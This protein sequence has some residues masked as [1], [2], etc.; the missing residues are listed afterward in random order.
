MRR[1]YYLFLVIALCCHGI[2]AEEVSVE[3]VDEFLALAERAASGDFGFDITLKNDLDFNGTNFTG[4]LGYRF[5]GNCTP[6][7]GIFEGNGHSLRGIHSLSNSENASL[8]CGI[9]DA[10]IKN[11]IIDKTCTWNGLLYAGSLAV[12]AKG[13][14][15]IENVINNANAY[16]G[17][18][19]SGFIGFSGATSLPDGTDVSTIADDIHVSFVKC[20]NNGIITARAVNYTFA[21]GFIG[22]INQVNNTS[23][24]IRN[25]TNY[26]NIFVSTSKTQTSYPFSFSCGG[27]G[28]IGVIVSD[29]HVLLAVNNCVN[30]GNIS[31]YGEKQSEIANGG[32]IGVIARCNDVS[33]TA[34]NCINFG[35]GNAV[36]MTVYSSG[37]MGMVTM[38]TNSSLSVTNLTNQGHFNS[39]AQYAFFGC[40]IGFIGYVLLSTISVSDSVNYGVFNSTGTTSVS[41]GVVGG[42]LENNHLDLNNCM[43]HGAIISSAY[44]GFLGGIVGSTSNTYTVIDIIINNCMN[45]GD[46]LCFS[47]TSFF[48]S[49]GILS[50][51]LGPAVVHMNNCSNAGDIVQSSNQNGSYG[52]GGLIGWL[53]GAEK[54]FINCENTGDVINYNGSAC[55]LFCVNSA[56]YNTTIVKNCVNK[57]SVSGVSATGISDFVSEANNVVSLGKVNGTNITYLLWDP[58]NNSNISRNTSYGIVEACEMCNDSYTTLHRHQQDGKFYYFLTND[59]GKQVRAD[60]ILNNEA[61]SKGYKKYWSYNLEQNEYLKVNVIDDEGKEKGEAVRYGDKMG[62]MKIM[63]CLKGDNPCFV[64]DRQ[65]NETYDSNHII[66]RDHELKIQERLVIVEIEFQPTESSEMNE[67]ELKEIISKTCGIDENSFIIKIEKNDKG[68]IEKVILIVRDDETADT[69]VKKVNEIAEEDPE[70]CSEGVLCRAKEAHVKGRPLI[71]E[72]GHQN[73]FSLF[74]IAISLILSVQA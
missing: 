17:I 50:S 63:K 12:E 58:T 70:K 39:T 66:K 38:I 33:V 36:S 64:I 68:Q 40:A 22:T 8:F 74:I 19:S 43:N 67:S 25:C 1:L 44:S 5:D 46:I 73:T 18:V 16:G 34:E 35:S 15:T 28:F 20:K 59:E 41:G 10:T 55:G 61:E 72:E 47:S 13:N 3:T 7:S 37:L 26:G 32:I 27:G 71:P 57:G 54:T 51:V 48:A 42:V 9:R 49:G 21:G 4:L 69:I 24:S 56:S 31:S 53:Y 62:E 2:L 11:L 14:V 52:V 45:D 23:V 6:Y 65:T 30:Y 29:N 60:E